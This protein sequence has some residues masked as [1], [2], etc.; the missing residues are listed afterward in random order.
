MVPKSTR[1][2]LRP[3]SQTLACS[4]RGAHPARRGGK[5]RRSVSSSA[6]MTL[7][8]GSRSIRRRIRR[9]FLSVRIGPQHVAGALPHLVHPMEH[10]S[11]GTR[12]DVHPHP[13]RQDIAEQRR[14]PTLGR[15]AERARGLHQE[16][17]HHPSQRPGQLRRSSASCAIVKR[18]QL[19]AHAEAADPVVQGLPRHPE[20]R[21][22]VDRRRALIQLQERDDALRDPGVP[23]ALQRGDK[24]SPLPRGQP[25]VPHGSPRRKPNASGTRVIPQQR[26]LSNFFCPPT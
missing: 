15:I 19:S 11:D 26:P 5:R 24:P 2:A 1:L 21:C 23:D 25:K 16:P 8:G 6:R 18:A 12:R 20:V 9:F 22:D 7:C 13:H 10:A 4:P 3:V 14:G 17:R